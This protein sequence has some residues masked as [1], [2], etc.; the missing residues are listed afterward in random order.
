MNQPRVIARCPACS[1]EV[2]RDG[3]C[4]NCAAL[5]RLRATAEATGKLRDRKLPT[6][7]LRRGLR[8]GPG[9]AAQLPLSG[10][11]AALPVGDRE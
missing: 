3:T 2:E 4:L 10:Q 11:D 8:F 6:R 9:I 5:A 7:G 1:G